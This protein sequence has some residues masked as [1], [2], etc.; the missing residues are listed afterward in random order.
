MSSVLVY[1]LNQTK[2]PTGKSE[3]MHSL[4]EKR[5]AE[6]HQLNQAL[7]KRLHPDCSGE[8][9]VGSQE[10]SSNAQEFGVIQKASY[11]WI[12]LLAPV[13]SVLTHLPPWGKFYCTGILQSSSHDGFCQETLGEGHVGG[14]TGCLSRFFWN[15]RNCFS[16]KGKLKSFCSLV[17]SF[18]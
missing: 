6:S 3:R 5:E 10:A 8:K 15:S 1:P 17:V 14:Q 16:P 12:S 7:L 4:P 9:A 18:L 13:I 11:P 2:K